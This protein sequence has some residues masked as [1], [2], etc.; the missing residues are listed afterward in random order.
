[1][2]F[3]LPAAGFPLQVGHPHHHQTCTPTE[4]DSDSK[5]GASDM[6]L[7]KANLLI[8]CCH[9]LSCWVSDFFFSLCPR[10]RVGK[11]NKQTNKQ[12]KSVTEPFKIQ[13]QW[14]FI[15]CDF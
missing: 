4:L 8:Y 1:M 15:Q 12:T 7:T 2:N 11:K 3:P 9:F 5:A 13:P 6:W 14:P 10:I